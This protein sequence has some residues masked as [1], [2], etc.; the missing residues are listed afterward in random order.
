MINRCEFCGTIWETET[1]EFRLPEIVCRACL[2][3][4]RQG[5]RVIARQDFAPGT[6]VRKGVLYTVDLVIRGQFE[7][8]V[9]LYGDGG[10]YHL[11]LFE[12]CDREAIQG[13]N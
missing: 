12:I 6:F 3:G 1:E 13:R 4:L 2:T 7:V 11:D 10:F 5:D 8:S 9:Q